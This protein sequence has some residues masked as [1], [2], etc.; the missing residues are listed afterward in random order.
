MSFKAHRPILKSR[1]GLF[2]HICRSFFKHVLVSFVMRIGLFCYVISALLGG[3]EAELCW[4]LGMCVCVCVCGC[5]FVCVHGCNTLQL[6]ATC[7]GCSPQKGWLEK[8]L[9]GA[10][11][12]RVLQSVAVYCNVL[13][14]VAVCCSVLQRVAVC[15][16]VLQTK[17]HFSI[18]QVVD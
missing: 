7:A 6:T 2:C 17:V 18:A 1:C 8:L 16:S 4:K 10:V 11:R 9:C 14:C 15:C 3:T 12:C 5:A 13:Q